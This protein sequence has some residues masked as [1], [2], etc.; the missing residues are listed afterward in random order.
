MRLGVLGILCLGLAIAL[1]PVLTA[2]DT[3]EK[4]V[5]DAQKTQKKV[6]KS[7]KAAAAGSGGSVVMRWSGT[8]RG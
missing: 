1:A 7:M 4:Q 3:V 2:G 8:S 5:P 6:A